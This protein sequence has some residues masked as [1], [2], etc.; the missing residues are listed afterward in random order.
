[1]RPKKALIRGCDIKVLLVG[2]VVAHNSEAVVS[3]AGTLCVYH[4]IIRVSLVGPFKL[5]F[6]SSM[7]A[8]IDLMDILAQVVVSL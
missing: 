2:V 4:I 5:H 8:S 3:R 6:R 1:M 7:E